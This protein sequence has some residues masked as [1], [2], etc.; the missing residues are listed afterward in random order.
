[1][2]RPALFLDRDGTLNVD[3]GYVGSIADLEMI[4]G[5]FDALREAQRR[6][7]LLII[8]TNQSGIG[9]GYFSAEAYRRLERYI[10]NLFETEGVKIA[11]TY[12]CPH[13]PDAGCDCRKPS[14]GLI[15]AAVRD[16]DIDLPR[17]AMVGDSTCDVAAAIAAGVGR[18]LQVGPN[19]SLSTAVT[20]LGWQ[21]VARGMHIID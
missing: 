15:L 7:Y 14:P 12:H 11:A 2:S 1:M 10:E 17:S 20:S 9:R 16:L 3:Y 4:P 8:V 6:G 13:T 21:N 19:L 5:V 18:T